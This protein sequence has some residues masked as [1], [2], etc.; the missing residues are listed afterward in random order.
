MNLAVKDYYY[1]KYGFDDVHYD[2][3]EF[4]IALYLYTKSKQ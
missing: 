3:K 1:F 4:I 2:A